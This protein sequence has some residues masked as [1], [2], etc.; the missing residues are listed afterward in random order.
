MKEEKEDVYL[1][2]EKKEE[3]VIVVQEEPI[4]IIVDHPEGEIEVGREGS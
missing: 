4:N 1:K 3:Q 2:G